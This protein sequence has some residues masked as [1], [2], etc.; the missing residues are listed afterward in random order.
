MIEAQRRAYLEALGLDVWI[1][2]SVAT[3]GAALGASA[4]QGSTLLICSS[5]AD[6]ETA[7]A[8]D[9]ARALGDDPVW[10]WL[11]LAAD[12]AIQRL[13]DLIVD[14]LIT[15]AVVF[16]RV[17]ARALFRG[18][19]PGIVGSATLSVAPPLEELAASGDARRDFWRQLRALRNAHGGGEPA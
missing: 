3:E 12:A 9:I 13:E 6:C 2:R 8:G 18:E 10:A 17:P 19:V 16:G 4:G 11:E 15:R 1:A 14:R 5:L 7:I